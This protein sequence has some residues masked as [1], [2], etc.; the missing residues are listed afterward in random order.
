MIKGICDANG[1]WVNQHEDIA[2]VFEN[3]FASLYTSS[4]PSP[5]AM[6]KILSAVL[7]KVT[8]KMNESLLREFT[9]RCS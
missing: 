3:Y 6:S 9:A 1:K 8:E 4:T 7:I 5:A 2:R